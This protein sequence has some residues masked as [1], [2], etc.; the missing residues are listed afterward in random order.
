M[1][2]LSD[3]NGEILKRRFYEQEIQKTKQPGV[4]LV[5]EI[6]K[7]KGD[8]ALVSWVGEKWSKIKSWIPIQDIY[9]VETK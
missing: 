6:L 9:G 1:Y 5:K 3:Y 4:Y 2:L 8:K 7:T